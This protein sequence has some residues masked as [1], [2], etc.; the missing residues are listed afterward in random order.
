MIL[1]FYC[2]PLGYIHVEFE[3][4]YHEAEDATWETPGAPEEFEILQ[5][6]IGGVAVDLPDLDPTIILS[7][8][9]A[10]GYL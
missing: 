3:V 4:S 1:S 8:L 9:K 10:E 6:C 5:T 7:M 2:G